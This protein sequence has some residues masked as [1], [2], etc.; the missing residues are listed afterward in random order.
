P[1]LDDQH[2]LAGLG[3]L[4]G[5]ASEPLAI[6][7]ALNVHA[8]NL[9]GVIT[10]EILEKVADLEV[11]LV[12]KRDTRAEADTCI[13]GAIVSGNHEGAALADK[14]DRAAMKLRHLENKG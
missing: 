14:A 11:S 12:A 2:G 9:R 10:D 8:D 4:L 5:Q 3:G 13:M 1:G 6:F 7:Q